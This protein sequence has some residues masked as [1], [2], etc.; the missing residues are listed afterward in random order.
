M[1]DGELYEACT[2]GDYLDKK[3]EVLVIDDEG[4]SLKVKKIES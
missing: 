1:I 4:A 3:E 2:R